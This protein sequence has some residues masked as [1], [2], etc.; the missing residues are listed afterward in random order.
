MDVMS[1]LPFKNLP[2]GFPA[3]SIWMFHQVSVRVRRS[4]DF[5]AKKCKIEAK[6]DTF[7]HR[8]A[9]SETPNITYETKR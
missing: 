1:P 3:I 4:F 8:L 9:L 2:R 6:K 7:L 5:E